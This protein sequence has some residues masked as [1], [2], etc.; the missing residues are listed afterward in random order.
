LT[1][2]LRLAPSS[3]SITEQLF[4]ELVTLS[5]SLIRLMIER[6][7]RIREHGLQAHDDMFHVT[8]GDNHRSAVLI[9]LRRSP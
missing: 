5:L 8:G 6:D 9:A 1:A 2:L 4:H 7:W 3:D